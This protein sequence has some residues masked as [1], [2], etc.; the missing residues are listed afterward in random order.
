MRMDHA[1]RLTVLLMGRGSCQCAGEPGFL[2]RWMLSPFQENGHGGVY[3]EVVST[4][5]LEFCESLGLGVGAVAGR[6]QC[7]G[8][9]ACAHLSMGWVPCDDGALI[10]KVMWVDVAGGCIC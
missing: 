10:G 8:A 9:C 6:V 3:P 5:G 2:S 4:V 1:V 7:C